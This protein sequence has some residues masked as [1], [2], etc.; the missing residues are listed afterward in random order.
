[1]DRAVKRDLDMSD[2]AGVAL[3]ITGS[4]CEVLGHCDGPTA[5]MI[6]SRI[7]VALMV[8]VAA[9]MR[10]EAR[11]GFYELTLRDV[12]ARLADCEARGPAPA[13]SMH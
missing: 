6:A 3:G 10:P 9:A 1:M 12:R 4:V 5:G 8:G 13:A 11:E 7:V 2:P